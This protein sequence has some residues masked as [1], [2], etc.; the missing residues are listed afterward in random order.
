MATPSCGAGHGVRAFMTSLAANREDP[1]L[2]N[3]EANRKIL[4][5]RV[6]REHRGDQNLHV[7]VFSELFSILW[8][9][10]FSRASTALLKPYLQC[11]LTCNG[12][13]HH[14]ANSCFLCL[15]SVLSVSSVVIIF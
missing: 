4:N 11:D 15:S 9:C 8:M 7:L 10:D 5:H 14:A 13:G 6:H 2:A 12:G 1:N 3:P